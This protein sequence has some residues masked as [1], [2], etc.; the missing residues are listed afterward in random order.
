MQFDWIGQRREVWRA[1]ARQV[2]FPMVQ[3]PCKFR[4]LTRIL[5]TAKA[6]YR[7]KTTGVCTIGNITCI[8]SAK[9]FTEGR[10]RKGTS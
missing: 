1:R 10:E 6:V 7:S 3:K 9:R 2:V 4:H 5:S 8:F